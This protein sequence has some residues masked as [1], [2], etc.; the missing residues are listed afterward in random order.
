MLDK[1]A[2]MKDYT[3]ME[4]VQELYKQLQENSI[5]VDTI[6][7]N[8]DRLE[9]EHTDFNLLEDLYRNEFGLYM[10]NISIYEDLILNIE[11][12]EVTMENEFQLAKI[13]KD[14]QDLVRVDVLELE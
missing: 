9:K 10:R 13:K 4:R 5:E 14:A 2:K 11:R 12:I 1:Y 6:I 8:L 7:E 3:N